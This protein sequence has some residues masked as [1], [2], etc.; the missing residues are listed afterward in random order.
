MRASVAVGGQP[1]ARGKAGLSGMAPR[2][3]GDIELEA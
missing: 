3:A 2:G 1:R